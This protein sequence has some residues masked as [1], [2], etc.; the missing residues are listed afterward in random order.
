METTR[1]PARTA[2]RQGEQPAGRE[3][4]EADR[5]I[6]ERLAAEPEPPAPSQEEADEI[7]ERALNPAPDE[8]AEP[9]AATPPPAGE[10]EAQRRE[11]ERQTRDQQR[12]ASGEQTTR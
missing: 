5:Q 11:R 2:P 3:R 1:E 12:T 4:D 10:T 8:A 7:K 6:A 9:K